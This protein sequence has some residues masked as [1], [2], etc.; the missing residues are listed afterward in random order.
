MK[1]TLTLLTILL[2]GPFTALPAEERES[3]SPDILIYGATPAGIAAALSA[4]E[5]NRKIKCR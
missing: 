4:A 5:G 2:L 1:H 3:D